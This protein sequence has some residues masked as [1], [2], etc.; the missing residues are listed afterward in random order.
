[1]DN[2]ALWATNLALAHPHRF[3]DGSGDRRGIRSKMSATGRLVFSEPK[4]RC[5]ASLSR[6]SEITT[7]GEQNAN[8]LP[9][10][11]VLRTCTFCGKIFGSLALHR[12]T[13]EGTR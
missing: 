3:N 1:M 5:R 10:A 9:L 7:I 12:A 2:F 13:A 6:L 4:Q 11:E 8:L